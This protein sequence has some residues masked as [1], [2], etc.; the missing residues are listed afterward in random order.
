VPASKRGN[1]FG[2][3]TGRPRRCGW[4]D[5]PALARS[6]QLN[7]VDGLCIT[8]LDV[9]DGMREI[10]ICTGYTVNG[11]PVAL[12]PSGADAVA[13]CIP[14]YETMPGWNES[15]V[16]ARTFDELPTAART[17]LRRIEALTGVPIAIVSTGPD[18]DETILVH[19]PF[20]WTDESTTQLS[21]A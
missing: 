5:I 20:K 21:P 18:R 6:F 17:Y 11:K 3:V 4:L 16:G 12:L 19:H 13:E 15:T 7:G 8:K 14:R 10:R 9:L 2:S 1:E